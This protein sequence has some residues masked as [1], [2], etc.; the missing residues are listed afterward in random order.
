LP[1]LSFLKLRIGDEQS[2]EVV[3]G[4]EWGTQYAARV[5]PEGKRII[6]SKLDRGTVAATMVRDIASGS[7]SAFT[8]LLRHPRW[9]PDGKLIAGTKADAFEI[10]LCPADGGTC[11]RLT[12]GYYPHWSS[13]SRV[14]FGRDSKFSD[15]EEV[16]S[17]S[18][19]GGDEVKVADLHPLHPIGQFFDVSPSGQIVWVQYQQ[20][21]NDLWL[22]QLP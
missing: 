3:P 9:S 15:G 8:M 14:Y 22:A 5:D 18:V 6:Y 16:W 2:T 13:S 20:G 11:H 1:A 7:E 10:Q 21:K 19:A 17:V 4:W 12:T